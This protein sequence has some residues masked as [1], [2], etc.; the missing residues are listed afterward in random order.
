MAQYVAD[1]CPACGS[2]TEQK[3]HDM[4]MRPV[5]P[6]CGHVVYFDPKVA[7]VAFIVQDNQVLLVQRRLDPGMGLW[8]L[9]GGYVEV[10]EHPEET[11]R[12][13][14]LEETGLTVE[15]G[16]VLDV[17]HNHKDGGVITI[18]Y[19]A[20]VVSGDIVPGDDAA[21]VGWFE[22]DNLPPL[23]FFSTVSLTERWAKDTL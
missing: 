16:R 5:C 13:E 6:A 7:A 17:F 19:A 23:V 8:A 2:R 1:F 14:T 22:K 10:N 12:R 20:T 4:K 15:I 21:D 3:M 11:A 9:A 18:A